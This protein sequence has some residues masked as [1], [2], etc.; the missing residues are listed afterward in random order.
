MSD[1]P[2]NDAAENLKATP[3]PEQTANF[4][5]M[6]AKLDAQEAKIAEM[7]HKAAREKAVGEALERLEGRPLGADPAAK[8]GQR[9]DELGAEGFKLYID[10]FA[11]TFAAL[12]GNDSEK[13]V[14]FAGDVSRTPEA[15]LAYTE[16]GTEAVEHAAKFAAEHKE[17]AER[18]M[19]RHSAE[20]YVLS[21]MVRA[22]FK[23]PKA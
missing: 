7:E 22:G 1:K 12:G 14:A 8:F 10:D 18:G 15:A 23:A 16:Q 5:A 9:Y 4:A 2:E 17:L 19:I 21:N 20:A 6:S 11:A 3:T 13:A